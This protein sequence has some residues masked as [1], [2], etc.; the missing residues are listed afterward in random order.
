M[1][2]MKRTTLALVVLLAG[3]GSSNSPTE[4]A[5]TPTTPASTF[6]LVDALSGFNTV[7]GTIVV[8]GQTIT[9]PGGTGGAGGTAQLSAGTYNFTANGL[10]AGFYKT[11]TGSFTVGVNPA[12]NNFTFTL[13]RN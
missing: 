10:P 12:T 4:P 7:G 3:C 13:L 9:V 6:H 2:A 1:A 11:M 8:G 5:S